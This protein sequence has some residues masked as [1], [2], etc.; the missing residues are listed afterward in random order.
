MSSPYVF[1]T[2]LNPSNIHAIVK[3]CFHMLSQ[4]LGPDAEQD[5]CINLI[6][7]NISLYMWWI[8]RI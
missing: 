5:L 2:Q 7:R 6:T 3:I 1:A 8:Y 4:R